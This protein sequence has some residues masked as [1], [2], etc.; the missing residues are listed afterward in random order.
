MIK[1]TV[2]DYK[3]YKFN[4]KVLLMTVSILSDLMTNMAKVISSNTNGVIIKIN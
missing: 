3:I 2:G 1:I 4:K